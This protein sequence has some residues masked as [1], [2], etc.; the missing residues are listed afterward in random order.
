MNI[1]LPKGYERFGERLAVAGNV[2][3]V[4]LVP[5]KEDEYDKGTKIG[6]FSL[7]SGRL[8]WEWRGKGSSY[9]TVLAH[10]GWLLVLHRYGDRLSV[11]DPADGRVVTRRRLRGH[12]FHS[13]AA[14]RGDVIA[15]SCDAV[16]D[17]GRLRVFRWR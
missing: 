9:A 6:A 7:S 12:G 13:R 4:R 10:R 16:D 1:A 15:L 2:L 8:L 5:T 3:A 11:L 17:T 14:A